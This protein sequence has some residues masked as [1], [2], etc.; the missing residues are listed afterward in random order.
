MSE[1]RVDTET[2]WYLY[3]SPCQKQQNSKY[4]IISLFIS[5]TKYLKPKHRR[6]IWSN[7]LL[8]HFFFKRTYNIDTNSELK[9]QKNHF[10]V[11]TNSNEMI[12]LKSRKATK[13]IFMWKRSSCETY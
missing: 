8:K 4:K 7:F 12:G 3:S 6:D 10:N 5:I 1:F 11:S 9:T 2:S 13:V